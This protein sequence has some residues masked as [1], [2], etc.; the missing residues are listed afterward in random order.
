M[1]KVRFGVIGLSMGGGQMKDITALHRLRAVQQTADCH[2]RADDYS[3][4]DS[5]GYLQVWRIGTRRSSQ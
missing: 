3:H 4:A 2:P 1:D 5:G